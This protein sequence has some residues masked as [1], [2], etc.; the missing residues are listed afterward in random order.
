MESQQDPLFK[1]F[2]R[3]LNEALL[4][5]QTSEEDLTQQIVSEYM[6]L[7]NARGFVPSRLCKYLEQDVKEEVKNM[8]R[9]TTYGHFSFAEYHKSSSQLAQRLKSRN[10]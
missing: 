1:I 4:L 8:F 2:R 5:E 7:L 3:H 9:K 6:E 10:N